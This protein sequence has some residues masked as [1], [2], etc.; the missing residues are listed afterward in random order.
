MILIKFLTTF[1]KDVNPE[2][3]RKFYLSYDNM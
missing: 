3:W 1:L 2:E